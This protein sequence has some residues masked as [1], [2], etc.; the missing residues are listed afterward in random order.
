MRPRP[1]GPLGPKLPAPPGSP[2]EGSKGGMGVQE[3][4]RPCLP[5][6]RGGGAVSAHFLLPPA[7]P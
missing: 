5:Q 3:R 4:E 6:L 7:F 1:L 2:Q